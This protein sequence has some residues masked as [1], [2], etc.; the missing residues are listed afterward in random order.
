MVRKALKQSKLYLKIL[1]YITLAMAACG[2]I[3]AIVVWVNKDIKLDDATLGEELVKFAKE[4]GEDTVRSMYGFT[5]LLSMAFSAFTGW[6]M[7]RAAKKPEKTTLLLVL[8]TFSVVSG[9]IA[10]LHGD[11]GVGATASAA[12]SLVVN[13]LALMATWNIRQSA[14]DQ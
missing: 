13:L 7:L 8:L 4:H 14:E 6:L 12:I 10:A 2:A 1:G 11:S 9:A 5:V 3:S